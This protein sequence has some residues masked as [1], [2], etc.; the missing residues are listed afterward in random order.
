MLQNVLYGCLGGR[1]DMPCPELGRLT[2]EDALHNPGGELDGQR[3]WSAQAHEHERKHV[4]FMRAFEPGIANTK[5]LMRNGTR[6]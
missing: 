5:P 2:R 1:D 4:G 6:E 3:L